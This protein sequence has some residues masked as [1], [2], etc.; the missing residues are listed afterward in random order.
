MSEGRLR[1]LDVLRGVAAVTVLI[2]HYTALYDHLHGVRNRLGFEFSEGGVYGVF[3]FFV[4]SGFVIR[5]TLDRCE[6]WKDFVVSRFSRIFPPY[7]AALL[8]TFVLLC[9]LKEPPPTWSQLAVN[10]T[11]LQRFFG[12]E[13]LDAVYWTLNVELSFYCWMLVAFQCRL[14]RHLDFLIAAALL[15]QLVVSLAERHF[16][17]RFS[18]GVQA[19]FLLEYVNFFGA[20]I[21]FYEIWSNR[22]SMARWALM[23]WCLANACAVPFRTFPC[24]PPPSWTLPATFLILLVFWLAITNRLR[25]LVHPI[26]LYFGTIS[27]TLYLVHDEIGRGLMN[28]MEQ[29]GLPP[30]L[31]F[32]CA[33]VVS[34]FLATLITF[35]VEK[36]AM[37]RIRERYRLWKNSSAPVKAG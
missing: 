36:P 17:H 5:M 32:L 28:R 4:I 11:M 2:S 18:Q 13:H 24:S 21:L 37:R 27:Y 20:G 6:G 19:V 7:W 3:L 33:V 10:L 35:L 1:E 12:F 14:L 9:W 31:T 16:A 8:V 30:L 29:S 15:F 25:W 26:T 22:S 34:M 23:A